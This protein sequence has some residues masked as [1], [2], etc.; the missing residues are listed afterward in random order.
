MFETISVQILKANHENLLPQK[1]EKHLFLAYFWA[2]NLFFGISTAQTH[3]D[4]YQT[5]FNRFY[6]QKQ[7]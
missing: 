7:V 5:T 2:R 4:H 6:R 3:S 1:L